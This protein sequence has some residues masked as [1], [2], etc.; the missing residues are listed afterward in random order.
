MSENS[1]PP[2]DT[3]KKE[4]SL[5]S[6]VTKGVIGAIS[7][8]GATAIPLVVQ[9]YLGPSTPPSAASPEASPTQL[10]APSPSSTTVNAGSVENQPQPLLDRQE[11]FGSKKKKS[12][13]KD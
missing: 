3:S 10:A 11:Q 12:K 5:K 13:V 4:D 2:P 7:L 9:R 6:L 8:A 1:S